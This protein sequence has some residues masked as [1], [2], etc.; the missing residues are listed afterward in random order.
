M[1]ADVHLRP[2]RDA[3][4]SA[5]LVV[6]ITTLPSRIG[7]IRPCLESLLSGSMRPDKI[8]L[9]LPKFSIREQ[10]AYDVPAFLDSPE[11]CQGIVDIVRTDHDWGPGSKLLGALG[12]L[13]EPCVLVIADDDVIYS[14]TF[15]A[16][17]Y[18]A[19][20]QDRRASFS[21]HTYRSNGLTIGPGCDGF[22]F[23]LPNLAGIAEFAERHIV[24]TNLFFH[25]DL[26]ISFYLKIHGI[27]VKSLADTLAGRL[28]YERMHD[29]NSLN[30]LEGELKRRNLD[31]DGTRRL[32][33]E[34]AMPASLRLRLRCERMFDR[35]VGSRIR[36]LRRKLRRWFGS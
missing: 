12:R 11:F 1:N 21:F 16:E 25:D 36:K 29:I 30:R 20:T 24:G 28:V 23:W 15:L 27:A 6:S 17:L 33:K 35:I 19:Q 18:A 32:L 26:W 5:K 9:I 2:G 31:R 10:R 4:V 8:F 7:E 14:P 34:V 3:E 22:T 13:R